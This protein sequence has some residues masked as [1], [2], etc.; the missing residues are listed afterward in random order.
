MLLRLGPE[1]K[2]AEAEKP[3]PEEQER[4]AGTYRNGA[5]TIELKWADG[6]LMQADKGKDQPVVVLGGSRY[7]DGK[8]ELFEVVKG[9]DGKAVYL[10]RGGRALH[11]Q[12]AP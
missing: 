8:G 4:L 10:F 6:K 2:P 9:R 3:S 1:P 12:D 7:R 5:M 11:K